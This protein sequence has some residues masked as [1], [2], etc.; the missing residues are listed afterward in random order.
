MAMGDYVQIDLLRD[1]W[2]ACLGS[3]GHRVAA[4]PEDIVVIRS[5]NGSRKSFRW[6]LTTSDEPARVFSTDERRRLRSEIA[7]ATRSREKPFVVVG[8]SREPR[9]IVA[10]PASAALAAGVIR[11]DRGGIAWED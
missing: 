2:L 6:V 1:S 11:S 5:R 3:R 7:L 9:R 10:I 4:V 8:F